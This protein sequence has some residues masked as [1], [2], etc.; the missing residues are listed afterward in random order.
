MRKLHFNYT[1]NFPTFLVVTTDL[2]T[3]TNVQTQSK[4]FAMHCGLDIH[5]YFQ[6]IK[7]QSVYRATLFCSAVILTSSNITLEYVSLSQHKIQVKL[8]YKYICV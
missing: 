5:V 6:F 7:V 3:I 4:Y 8:I 1:F 2:F